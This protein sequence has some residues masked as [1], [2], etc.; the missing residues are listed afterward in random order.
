MTPLFSF[1]YYDIVVRKYNFGKIQEL[2][3]KKGHFPSPKSPLSFGAY[4]FVPELC[5][6]SFLRMG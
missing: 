5:L 3:W 6:A 4:L 1:V 2:N